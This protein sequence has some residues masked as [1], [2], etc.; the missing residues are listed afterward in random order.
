[1]PRLSIFVLLA[2]I[3]LSAEVSPYVGPE[4]C[5]ACHPKEYQKQIRSHHAQ[6]LRPIS[7]STVYPIL[8]SHPRTSVNYEAK[9]EAVEVSAGDGKITA[10]LEWAFG[11]GAQGVTPV[12]TYRGRYFEHRFSFYSR[13]Q[14]LAPTFGHPKRVSTAEAELGILQDG[15]TISEC[16]SCHATGVQS[17]SASPDLSDM[18]PGV[19]CE[20]C[21]G[22]ARTHV[23]AASSGAAADTIRRSLVN[24]KRFPAKAQV[25]ICGECHRL[26]APDDS[27]PEPEI[28]NPV[29]VRFAPIG[30]MASRCFTKSK[31]LSCATCH[32]PHE[33]ALPRS[34]SSYVDRCSGCH[35]RAAG[36]RSQCARPI[37]RNCL[38]CHMRQV[39]LGPY[40]RFT[41]HRIRV[42]GK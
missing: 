3:A 29:S 18:R 1:M 13:P 41:D 33:D 20:R 38:S 36:S 17:G 15:K 35:A 14:Q 25:E 19:T 21:H 24:P 23:A 22:P 40:L 31:R 7:Q 2:G 6:A 26:P 28:E 34:D 9:K 12:G 8:M 11:A 37:S 10:L 27:S 30:L 39:E 4:A 32:D 42:Y 16:F 5:G